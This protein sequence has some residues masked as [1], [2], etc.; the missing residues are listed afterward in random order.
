[1]TVLWM[2]G[3]AYFREERDKGVHFSRR[4]FV[5]EL[6]YAE[7]RNRVWERYGLGCRKSRSPPW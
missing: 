2:A 6:Q 4:S 7:G 3:D 1:M 5:A